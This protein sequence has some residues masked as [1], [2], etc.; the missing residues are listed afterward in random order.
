[1]GGAHGQGSD[2]GMG[3]ILIFLTYKLLLC[4]INR[5]E[6][7]KI[8]RT[9]TTIEIDFSSSYLKGGSID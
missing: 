2:Y 1:M 5:Q 3:L 6:K 7:S 9:V 8:G 4:K